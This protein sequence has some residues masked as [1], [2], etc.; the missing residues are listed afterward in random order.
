MT[1][2]KI[3]IL[4]CLLSMLVSDAIA[5]DYSLFLNPKTGSTDDAFTLSIS[6]NAQKA[7][8][9]GEILFDTSKNFSL[10]GKSKGSRIQIINGKQTNEKTFNFTFS[11]ERTLKPGTYKL[12]KGRF[13]NN[14][15]LIIPAQTVKIVKG[16]A[17][18][19]DIAQTLSNLTP[20]VGE[21]VTYKVDV[22]SGTKIIDANID[23]V[24]F[25]DFW[26]ESYGD[27]SQTQR[28]VRD[29]KVIT[30][31][32]ALFPLKPGSLQIPARTLSA[33]IY[34]ID[35][36]RRNRRWTIFDELVPELSMR[37]DYRKKSIR[38]V[39]SP[40]SLN[41]KKLPP[42]PMPYDGTVPVG[43]VSISSKTDKSN[44]SL[45][46]SIN[47]EIIISGDANLRS[48]NLPEIKGKDLENFTVYEDK[49]DLKVQLKND[50]I[51]FT[52]KFSIALLAKKPGLFQ[53]PHYEILTFNP[54]KKK[55][56]R[57]QTKKTIV[58]VKGN[59]KENQLIVSSSEDTT[60]SSSYQKQEV[61]LLREDILAIH[62]NEQLLKNKKSLP[63]NTI[64]LTFAIGLTLILLNKFLLSGNKKDEKLQ[65]HLEAL[66]NAQDKLTSAKTPED[67]MLIYRNYLSER[68]ATDTRSFTPLDL[69]EKLKAISNES[70]AQDSKNT[71][72]KLEKLLF[73]NQESGGLESLKNEIL[74][75]LKEINENTSKYIKTIS[76]FIFALL[77]NT[78]LSYSQN[79]V[80]EASTIESANK[81]YESGNY[82]LAINQYEKVILNGL[83]NAHIH[84]NLGNAFLKNQQIGKAIFHYR[85]AKK[86][87]PRDPDIEANLTFARTKT[88][89]KLGNQS[90][91]IDSLLNQT[92]IFRKYLSNY[93]TKLIWI[94]MFSLTCFFIILYD[95]KK[96]FQ[97]TRNV[98]LLLLVY[99]SFCTFL[100][101]E[102]RTG[103]IVFSFDNKLSGVILEKETKVYSGDSK[104]YQVIFIINEG[105]EVS[106]VDR[107][108]GW[109]AIM[110]PS[111][112][113]G[114]IEDDEIGVI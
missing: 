9:L 11:P 10:T 33:G 40:L 8:Q 62:K 2:K 20:Y 13:E 81:A 95:R 70:L 16:S 71:L 55:Y 92:L 104:N 39:A 31:K 15:N 88:I 45:G 29:V 63:K 17:A 46:D 107:R 110:L 80:N 100:T 24:D 73:S 89:D 82:Q 5:S 52:K 53:L 112:V 38:R 35:P 86:E 54:Q 114:W 57:Y 44:V 22:A 51:F 42:A 75:N 76:I 48:F 79:L 43:I 18:P 90:K 26:K 77:L 96:Q 25:Q 49:A 4:V 23:E 3:L 103:E 65:T 7:D 28:T 91:G 106:I 85:I 67:I 113:K 83:D 1:G 14:S 47:L 61:N 37:N 56:I 50:R 99:W 36:N 105:A 84:Y 21:Q 78:N 97:T 111:G 32:E 19:V 27:Q 68:L 64:P 6:L 69:E 101:K 74:N 94:I 109:S 93:E 72:S 59:E 41:V 87:L 98:F 108:N 102:N 34:T 60:A 58:S 30:I 66:K 12:P